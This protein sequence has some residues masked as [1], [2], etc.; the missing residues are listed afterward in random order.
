MHLL[1]DTNIAIGLT[2]SSTSLHSAITA[3][4]QNPENTV[5]IS[6]A[7]IW[8]AEIK[9][10]LGKLIVPGGIWDELTARGFK[11]LTITRRHAI[12]AANLPELH[13]DPFDRLLV[14]QALLEGMTLVTRDRLL[15]AYGVPVA[16]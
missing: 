11:E 3:S 15:S 4:L 1:L 13:K 16:G 8:E 5:W 2:G 7:S 12:A 10:R 9:R 6:V 14:A